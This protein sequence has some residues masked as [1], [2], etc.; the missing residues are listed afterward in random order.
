[1]PSIPFQ[2]ASATA[3]VR[4]VAR[5]EGFVNSVFSRQKSC[6]HGTGLMRAIAEWADKEG[7]R[8]HLAVKPYSRDGI[9]APDLE[10]FY[11]KHGFVRNPEAPGLPIKMVRD[12]R[13]NYMP[14]NET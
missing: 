11:S 9:D 13:K 10:L 4:L 6:G 3:R 2:Y 8:L 1:M 14:L 12:P 5:S 7:V